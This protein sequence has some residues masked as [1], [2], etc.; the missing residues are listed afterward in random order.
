MQSKLTRKAL[1]EVESTTQGMRA[2]CAEALKSLWHADKGSASL[3][4]HV[5][6]LEQQLYVRV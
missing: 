5:H 1:A 3:L 6:E 4:D 2:E